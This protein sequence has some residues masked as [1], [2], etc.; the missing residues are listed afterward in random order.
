MVISP[1]D[2]LALKNLQIAT[3]EFDGSRILQPHEWKT[4]I[5]HLMIQ[6]RLSQYVKMEIF[7]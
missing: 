2:S 3:L 1:L 5:N 7:W 6:M 4:E